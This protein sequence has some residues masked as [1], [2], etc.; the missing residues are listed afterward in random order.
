MRCGKGRE[1]RGRERLNESRNEAELPDR[2][3]EEVGKREGDWT[4]ERCGTG[5]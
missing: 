4:Q 1:E 3:G 5:Q 2:R